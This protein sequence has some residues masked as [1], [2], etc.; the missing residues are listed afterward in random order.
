M[1]DFGVLFYEMGRYQ[2]WGKNLRK[3]V[4]MY[5]TTLRSIDT[6][7]D[8]SAWVGTDGEALKVMDDLVSGFQG[9]AI[10]P[11]SFSGQ[12]PL[13]WAA[14]GGYKAMVKLL[15]DRGATIGM[16]GEDDRTPL[17]WAAENG[18]EAVVKLLLDR[19]V[20]TETKDNKYGRTP[21][22]WAAKSGYKAVVKL[23]LG[24][25]IVTKK[26]DKIGLTPLL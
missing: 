8:H 19:G 2:D 1:W 7:P 5:T 24:K 14:A 15:L 3:A 13:S 22:L 21:L 10:E 25:G 11:D 4:E 6:Y 16:K 9:A 12:T 17:S 23:L 18:Y 26:K 20:V